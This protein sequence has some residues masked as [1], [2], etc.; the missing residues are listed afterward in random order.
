MGLAAPQAESLGRK[1][2]ASVASSP[3]SSAPRGSQHASAR[4]PNTALGDSQPGPRTSLEIMYNS[5]CKCSAFW[6]PLKSFLELPNS[7][8]D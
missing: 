3:V 1:L 4:D 6:E 8:Q 5:L 2:G 7:F